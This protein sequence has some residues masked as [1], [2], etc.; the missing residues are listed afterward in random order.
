MKI[1]A[2]SDIHG[3]Y[4]ELKLPTGDV[5]VCAGDMLNHGTNDELVDFV[6][7]LSWLDFKEIIV[8][9]GNHDWVFERNPNGANELFKANGLIL[10]NDSEVII[11]GIKFWG[12]PVTPYFHNWAFNRARTPGEVNLYKVPLIKDHWDKIPKDTDVLITHGPPYGILD[13]TLYK[14][15]LGCVDLYKA[16]ERVKPKVHIFGHIHYCGGQQVAEGG[17]IYYNVAV[18]DEWYSPVNL[19]T[20]FVIEKD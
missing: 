7:W 3:M 13:E 11:D 15:G 4:R 18:C 14:S 10:L 17:T 2:I 1:I 9:P 16:I 20:E 6:D 12:S 5:L 8:I 19:V